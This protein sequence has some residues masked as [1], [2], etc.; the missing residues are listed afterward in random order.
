MCSIFHRIVYCCLIQL[1]FL[2]YL[3]S[4][5]FSLFLSFSYFFTVLLFPFHSSFFLTP[6]L[7]LHILFYYSLLIFPFFLSYSFTLLSLAH[8]FRRKHTALS[9]ASCQ[10]NE[11]NVYLHI[12]LLVCSTSFSLILLT[13]IS[14]PYSA[15]KTER[16]PTISTF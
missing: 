10:G 3:F 13:D 4:S 16:I 8:V 9:E 11:N 6:S 7:Y 5:S 14:L 15:I 2:A 1:F 12:F